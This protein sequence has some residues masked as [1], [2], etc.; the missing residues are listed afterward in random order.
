MKAGMEQDGRKGTETSDENS[1]DSSSSPEQRSLQRHAVE[2]GDPGMI[3]TARTI[4]TVIKDPLLPVLEED[5][6]IGRPAGQIRRPRL[7][8]K[9]TSP[10]FELLMI[11]LIPH[12]KISMSFDLRLSL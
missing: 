6:N 10:R 11:N 3:T 4:K 5:S 9:A 7:D 12:L 1:I 8:H 2:E